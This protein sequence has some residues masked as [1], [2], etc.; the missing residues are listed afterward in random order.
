MPQV[1]I[2]TNNP[3]WDSHPKASI[4]YRDE[5]LLQVLTR[6]R[7]LVHRHYCLIS[8]P[9]AGSIKPNATP[10]KSVLLGA[11]PEEQIDPIS[12]QLIE[13]AVQ[14]STRMLRE[15][16]PKPMNDKVRADYA[17]IDMDLIMNALETLI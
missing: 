14:V 1:L 4:Q 3:R 7:D 5:S 2:I 9:L 6:V 10:Y 17:L 12:L 13:A 16:P 8:H 11:V 15:N